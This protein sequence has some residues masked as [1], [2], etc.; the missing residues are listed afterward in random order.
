M[1][2]NGDIKNSWLVQARSFFPLL[3]DQL[4]ESIF[5]KVLIAALSDQSEK[6]IFRQDRDPKLLSLAQL[7]AGGLPATTQVVFL[8]TEPD[9]L[10]PWASSF[11][12]ASF[13]E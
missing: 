13:R 5:C 3:I 11:S 1:G 12:P 6:L 7:G 2:T 4:A 10:A 8:D 9:T